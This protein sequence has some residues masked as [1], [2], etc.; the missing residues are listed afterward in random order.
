MI[1]KH[2]SAGLFI[3]GNS[4]FFLFRNKI[5]FLRR[6][7]CEGRVLGNHVKNKK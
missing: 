7:F 2:H 1:Q 4:S 5:V 3:S 6:A